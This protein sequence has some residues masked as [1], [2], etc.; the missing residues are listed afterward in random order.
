MSRWTDEQMIRWADV[1]ADADVDAYANVY[2][3][4]DANIDSQMINDQM[5]WCWC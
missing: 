1:D 5:S 4:S 3:D 2:F